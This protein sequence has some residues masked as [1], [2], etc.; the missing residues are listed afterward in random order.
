[1]LCSHLTSAFASPCNFVSVVMLMQGLGSGPFSVCVC[2]TI[3]AM[4]N[5]NGHG[6]VDANAEVKCE[7]SISFSPVF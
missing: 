5:C 3:D 1:M 4:L 2:L 7:Q 6:D